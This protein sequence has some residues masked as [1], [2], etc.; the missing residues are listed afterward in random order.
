MTLGAFD[1][2]DQRVLIQADIPQ[3]WQKTEGKSGPAEE[4]GTIMGEDL[5]DGNG[6]F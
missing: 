2:R 3:L 5:G 4:Q 1:R 6:H